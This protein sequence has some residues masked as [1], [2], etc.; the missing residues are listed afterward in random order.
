[1]CNPA[2]AVLTQ[3]KRLPLVWDRLRTPVPTWQSLLP[4]TRDPRD[5]DGRN[6]DWVVKPALGRVGEDV[7]I[8][9]VTEARQE[10]GIRKAVVRHHGLWAAQKRFHIAPVIADG[11]AWYACVG[12]YTVGGKAAGTYGR[13]SR[14]PLIDSSARDVPILVKE[15]E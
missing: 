7:L 8:P 5:C 13:V 15:G 6:E 12:I 9:G 11:A 2:T 3:S 4:E 14:T 10:K 1:M